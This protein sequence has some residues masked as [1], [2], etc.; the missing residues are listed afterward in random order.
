MSGLRRAVPL[1]LVTGAV[2]LAAVLV[3]PTHHLVSRTAGGSET[4]VDIWFDGR[5]RAVSQAIEVQR[6]SSLT[7]VLLVVAAIVL[8]LAAGGLWVAAARR[9]PVVPAVAVTAATLA[10]LAVAVSLLVL[11]RSEPFSFG[12]VGSAEVGQLDTA[13]TPVALFLPAVVVLGALAIVAMLTRVAR[14]R[15]AT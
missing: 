6:E 10:A 2:L 1:L 7:A 4:L 3:W 5:V 11:V 13:M 8:L 12:W 9:T 15:V 14:R